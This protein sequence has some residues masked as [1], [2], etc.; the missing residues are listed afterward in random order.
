M[1][2]NCSGKRSFSQFNRTKIEVCIPVLQK[3]ITVCP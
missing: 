2:T 1:V 3:K